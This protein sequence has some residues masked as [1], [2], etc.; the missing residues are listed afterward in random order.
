[1]DESTQ[2]GRKPV[3]ASRLLSSVRTRIIASYLILL[4]LGTLVS[5][6]VVR[7]IFIVRLE[8]RIDSQL[9]QEVQEFR[10]LASEGIDPT[11]GRPFGRDVDRLFEVF[12]ERNVPAEGEELIAIPRRGRPQYR[13]SE[14]AQRA[15]EA[16]C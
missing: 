15:V 12:L 4:T 9:T 1:M 14:R 10:R 8:D 16:G 11:T 3:G 6:L 13:Y 7:Q 5:V 2:P